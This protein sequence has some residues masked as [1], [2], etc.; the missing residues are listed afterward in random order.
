MLLNFDFHMVYIG[1]VFDC[2]FTSPVVPGMR[3]Y[4][5]PQAK[6]KRLVLVVA[7]GSILL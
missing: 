2:S 5:L 4:K 7:V 1:T 3:Q 6:A